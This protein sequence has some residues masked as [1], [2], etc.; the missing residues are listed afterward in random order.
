M[1]NEQVVSFPNRSLIFQQIVND[2]LSVRL[3]VLT[4]ATGI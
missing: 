3:H 2:F 4:T 1:A